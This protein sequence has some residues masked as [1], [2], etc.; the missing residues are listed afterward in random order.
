MQRKLRPVAGALPG[1]KFRLDC[2]GMKILE[3]FIIDVDTFRDLTTLE[4]G[5]LIEYICNYITDGKEPA[6]T[7]I[8]EAAR[9][10]WRKLWNATKR[11]ME[12][13]N[14][15]IKSKD[16]TIARQE[17]A[18]AE[19]EQQLEESDKDFESIFG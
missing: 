13:G 4:R 3:T 17:A 11:K 5:K 12:A 6:F 2:I 19:L 9:P 15:L 18:I 16:D 10:L 14:E 1:A 7:D 8:K